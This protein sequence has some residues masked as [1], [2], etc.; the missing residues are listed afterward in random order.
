[1]RSI[2]FFP[3]LSVLFFGLIS[4]RTAPSSTIDIEVDQS[5]TFLTSM[6]PN[7]KTELY[8]MVQDAGF[9]IHTFWQNFNFVGIVALKK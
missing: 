8:K 1:M 5:S 2:A 9:E 4:C 6:K 7:T 3:L